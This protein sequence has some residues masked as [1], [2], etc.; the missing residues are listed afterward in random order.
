MTDTHTA[1]PKAKREMIAD[2]QWVDSTGAE[3]KDESKATGFRYV[4]LGTGETK[5]AKVASGK[6]FLYKFNETSAGNPET[7]L[8]IFGGLT[9]AGNIVNTWNHEK[10]DERATDPIEAISDWFAM[11]DSGKWSEE[12]SGGGIARFDSTALAKALAT[13]TGKPESEFVAKL[14]PG[15]PKITIN[16]QNKSDPAGKRSVLYGTYALYNTKVKEAYNAL[17]GASEPAVGDL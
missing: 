2:R 9:K 10:P 16:A 3:T 14:A 1:T 7:M 6:S 11:L 8:A 5:E 17:V 15:A 13:V 12:R 4:L